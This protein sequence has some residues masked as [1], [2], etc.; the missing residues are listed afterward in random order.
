[1]G[2]DRVTATT[3]TGR[4]TKPPWR[5]GRE[6]YVEALY[7]LGRN[8]DSRNAHQVAHARRVLARMRRS[9]GDDRYLP[10]VL[11]L[12]ERHGPP[13]TEQE[14]EVWVYA[15]GLYALAPKRPSGGSSGGQPLGAALRASGD[16]PSTEARLRQLLAADWPT[17]RN[18]LR[19]AVQLIRGAGVALDHHALLDDLVVLRTEP[20]G[21]V[22]AHKVHLRWA[23]D[24]RRGPRTASER[25]KST[26]GTGAP[27]PDAPDDHSDEPTATTVDNGAGAPS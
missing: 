27:P 23:R 15:A 12:V 17:L 3:D 21:G 1:M 5:Q 18:R 10:D 19:Q 2:S 26:D 8:L 16:G 11:D 25:A 22:R 24:F 20:Q 9:L 13:G 4:T 7:R 6:D 14:E